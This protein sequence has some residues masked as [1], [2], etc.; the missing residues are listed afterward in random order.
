M[1]CKFSIPQVLFIFV[2]LGTEPRASCMLGKCST[3]ELYSQTFQLF[4][5]GSPK[6]VQAV[7]DPPPSASHETR[8]IKSDQYQQVAC[9]NKDFRIKGLY[10]LAFYRRSGKICSVTK[11]NF[12]SPIGFQWKH[13]RLTLEGVP[14]YPRYNPL[15][16]ILHN[17]EG[18]D[19]TF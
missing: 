9:L 14:G 3:P 12:I 13:C 6:V 4:E 2:V 10:P 16:K 15:S 18:E 19:K 1:Q 17:L 7:L 5:T 8:I 11:F